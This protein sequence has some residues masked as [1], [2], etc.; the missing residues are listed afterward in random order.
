MTQQCIFCSTVGAF[1][2]REHI[3]PESL[4]G[5]DTYVMRR[6]CV[7]DR[8]QNYFGSKVERVALDNYPFS[9]WRTFGGIPTKG[10]KPPSFE[11]A[12]GIFFGGLQQEEPSVLFRPIFERALLEGRKTVMRLVAQPR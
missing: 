1:S 9:H 5:D 4:G 12:E 7:C 6:Q 11:D 2:T 10:G 3:L 8:C